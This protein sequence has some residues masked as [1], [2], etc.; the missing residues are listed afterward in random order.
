MTRVVPML[1]DSAVLTLPLSGNA[2]PASTGVIRDYL[3]HMDARR[4][5]RALRTWEGEGG[6]LASAKAN[7]E[8]SCGPDFSKLM[9][10]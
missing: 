7:R 1:G 8:R 10:S 5:R 2:H 3:R 4:Y 9:L 6:K